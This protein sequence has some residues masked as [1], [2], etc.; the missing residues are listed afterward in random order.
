M[1]CR[2]PVIPALGRLRQED[3]CKFETSL[4]Y[5]TEFKAS[6][7]CIVRPYLEKFLKVKVHN[8]GQAW[9]HIPVILAL[10]RLR[11]EDQCGFKTSLGYKT[12][13]KASLNC[14]ERP[15]LKK[16]PPKK[17]IYW[18]CTHICFSSFIRT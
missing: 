18:I 1:W 10:G 5:K 8:A 14:I 4:G 3:R 11:Q 7:S 16:T 13:L 9:W 12:E 2:T 15:C 6:L 17:S